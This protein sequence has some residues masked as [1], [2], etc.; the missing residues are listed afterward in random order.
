MDKIQLRPRAVCAGAA[1]AHAALLQL[2][3]PCKH[4]FGRRALDGR[5]KRA[6]VARVAVDAVHARENDQIAR[7][8]QI[9]DDGG[10]LIVVDALDRFRAE[11]AHMR[12]LHLSHL[13]NAHRVVIVHDR[14]R[15][16]L[17]A[18]QQER[19]DVAALFRVVEVRVLH[20]KLPHGVFRPDVAAVLA[21][22]DRLSLRGVIRLD[23]LGIAGELAP[24]PAHIVEPSDLRCAAGYPDHAGP[25]LPPQAGKDVVIDVVVGLAD[26]GH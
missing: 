15:V 21:H 8:H 12:E 23:L 1:R 14:Y 19:T 22:E 9:A 6:G 17:R 10:R 5:H 4:L 13:F 3:Q 26:Q 20:K 24:L 2:V 25:E 18:A 7:M 16:V 11:R